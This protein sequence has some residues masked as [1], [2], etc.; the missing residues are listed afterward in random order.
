M[1]NNTFSSYATKVFD[2]FVKHGKRLY[3]VVVLFSPA[4]RFSDEGYN[5]ESTGV[6]SNSKSFNNS[7]NLRPPPPISPTRN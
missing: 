1:A 3:I 4:K 5:L 6:S 7:Y 2:Q